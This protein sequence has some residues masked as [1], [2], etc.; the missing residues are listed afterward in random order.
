MGIGTITPNTQA[1]ISLR[2][3]LNPQGATQ[4][5][6][7]N[8]ATPDAFTAA[9]GASLLIQVPALTT[10]YEV[11]LAALFAAYTAPLFVYLYDATTPGIGFRWSTVLAGQ[12]QTVGPGKWLAWMADGATA[13]E[14]LF[15]D[16]PSTNILCLSVG[17]MSN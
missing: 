10:D 17:V 1:V 6:L 7:L 2:S 11:D 9:S 14:S 12:K 3:Y 13:L 15:V 8:Y 4:Q 5:S 16:N